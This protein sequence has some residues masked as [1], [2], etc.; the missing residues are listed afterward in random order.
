MFTRKKAGVVGNDRLLHVFSAL[1]NATLE[2]G[3]FLGNTWCIKHCSLCL[4]R[5]KGYRDGRQ[6]RLVAH[7]A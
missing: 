5:L 1:F 2:E 4:R 7:K 6:R 3:I